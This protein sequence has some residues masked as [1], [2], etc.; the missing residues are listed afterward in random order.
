M[1][2]LKELPSTG[3]IIDVGGGG[4]G[5][6]SRIGGSQ[7]CAVDI[8]MSKIR[9]AQIHGLES[10][11]ILADGR[12]LAA[13]ATS[14]DAAT[15]WFSLGFIRDWTAKEEVI[16]EIARVLKP[17]GLISILGATID[18]SEQRFVL[19]GQF[20][21][22]DGSISMMSY[23]LAGRQNQTIETVATLLKQANFRKLAI[24]DNRYWFRIEARM[25]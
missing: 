5:F 8:E 21:L 1:I 14:F 16:E 15:L 23:G 6:V 24:E 25:P 3:T 10:Q 2:E 18:C 13:K 4:E 20:S 7:V 9:E 19:R 11:W 17:D 12:A 22:P